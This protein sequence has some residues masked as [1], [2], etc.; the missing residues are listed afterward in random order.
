METRAAILSALAAGQSPTR[1][2]TAFQVSR[3][4]VYNTKN[5][6]ITTKTIKSKPRKG[7]PTVVSQ[8]T[9]RYIYRTIR[10]LSKL[11]WRAL[12]AGTP[13]SLSIST[14]KRVL[15]RYHIEK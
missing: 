5:R 9:A 3:R 1:I 10:R 12:A 11:S 13:D 2:A 4:V 7:R 15:R 6:W 14:V 8:S